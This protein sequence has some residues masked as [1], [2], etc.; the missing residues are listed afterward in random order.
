MSFKN[1]V[2]VCSSFD[3]VAFA[4]IDNLGMKRK[5]SMEDVINH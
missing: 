1:S 5:R 3:F 2:T 4:S